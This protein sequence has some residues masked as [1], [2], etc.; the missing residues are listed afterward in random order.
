MTHEFSQS[1]A[2]EKLLRWFS[3]NGR[4]M[5]WRVKGRAHGNPYAVWISEIMLQQTTVKTVVDYFNRWMKRFP[6]ID[7][8]AKA[9]LQE[10]LLYWQGLGYYTRAK[11]IYEC[12]HVLMK[13]YGGKIPNNRELLLKLPGI[14]PYSASSICAFAFNQPE[15]VVDGNVIRVIARL[16]GLT[17]AVTKEEIYRLSQ[18]MTPKEHGAD[19][20]S[21]IMD[22]GA[23]VCTPNKPNC[24]HCPW[25]E[26]CKAHALNIAE[27]IPLIHKPAKKIKRG[28]VYLIQNDS[29]A[30]YIEKR[31]GKGLLS[32][33]FEFPWQAD[34]SHYPLFEH[35]CWN[36]TQQTVS[37]T[38][39]HFQLTLQIVRLQVSE[40][41][42]I[43]LSN[44]IFVLPEHFSDYPFSTLMKKVMKQLVEKEPRLL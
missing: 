25:R 27:S 4:D 26:I 31:A 28:Y 2:A 16:Y 10:V 14:G 43:P 17:H 19:Y 11:K 15:T 35:P 9:D 29:G 6:T 21:A 13:E 3:K 33:L 20:A 38:F 24:L 32:G 34:E 42:S 36:Q 8:L 5:P 18:P 30:F 22:L 41:E 7:S 37:H 12:A 1:D 39:T 40:N 23:T 44:G